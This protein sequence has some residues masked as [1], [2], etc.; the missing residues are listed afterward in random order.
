MSKRR[1]LK[2]AV[3]AVTT[4]S[5]VGLTSLSAT[6]ASAAPVQTR[7]TSVIAAPPTSNR[8]VNQTHTI[9]CWALTKY[10]TT[11]YLASGGT[12]GLGG[13]DLVLIQCYY[14]VGSTVYDH[15]TEEN[16][17]NLHDIGHINDSAINLDDSNPWSLP[18]KPYIPL[19]G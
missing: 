14:E 3:A 2:L 13:S 18:Y 12:V 19:C 7:A 4:A 15:V 17:G 10:A 6:A 9:A 5:T 8:C 1:I 16:G 11:L